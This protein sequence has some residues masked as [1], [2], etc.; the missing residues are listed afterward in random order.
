MTFELGSVRERTL[1]LRQT[2]AA[3]PRTPKISLQVY[4]GK[5]MA[6]RLQWRG[7]LL[8]RKV[9]WRWRIEVLRRGRDIGLLDKLVRLHIEVLGMFHWYIARRH[10]HWHRPKSIHQD[11]NR[12]YPFQEYLQVSTIIEG[13]IHGAP[14]W[15]SAAEA[16][17]KSVAPR[18][19]AS[20]ERILTYYCRASECLS[21]WM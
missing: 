9:V 15:I 12:H 21:E 11:S 1:A 16:A 7:W 14:T 6:R 18:T 20:D 4:G 2:S 13:K 5:Y 17:P 10:W 19:R 8:G 3:T